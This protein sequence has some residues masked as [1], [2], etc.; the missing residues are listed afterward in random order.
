MRLDID[1]LLDILLIGV[2][3]FFFS[4]WFYFAFMGLPFGHFAFRLVLSILAYVGLRI[5]RV[6]V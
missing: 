3:V 4:N 1:L 5:A 2:L 6:R